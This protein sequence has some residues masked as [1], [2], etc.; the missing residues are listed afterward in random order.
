VDR[1]GAW[2]SFLLAL[3][4]AA[5]AHLSLASGTWAATIRSPTTGD[6][7]G[8]NPA[9][10]S[11][12]EAVQSANLNLPVGGCTAGDPGATDRISFSSS[13]NGS[14]ILLS[15]G[16]LSTTSDL[17]IIGNGPTQTIV[18][19][20]GTTQPFLISGGATALLQD[21]TIV[22]G[23]AINGGAVSNAGSLVLVNSSISGS[24]ATL[25]G[26]VVNAG[27]VVSV[28]N[29]T[30]S[31]NSATN[32]GAIHNIGGGTVSVS[33]STLSGNA[34]TIGGAI[35]NDAGGAVS[36]TATTLSGNAGGSSAGGIFNFSTGTVSLR[37]TL[38]DTGATGANCAGTIESFGSNLADDATCFAAAGTDQVVGNVRIGPLADNGG[39]TR[40]HALAANS[41]AIDAVQ[42]ACTSDGSDG[43]R[44]LATDQRGAMRPSLGRGN[45]PARCDVGAYELLSAG[46]LQFSERAYRVGE[47]GPDATITIVRTG[48]DAGPAGA[49]LTLTG[50]TATLSEDYSGATFS[51]L[52]ADGE[53]SKLVLVPIVDDQLG[54][55]EE[56]VT[57]RL[58]DPTDG[59]RL[60]SSATAAL[61]IVDNDPT[62]SLSV[63]D[64]TLMEGSGGTTSFVFTVTLSPPSGQQVTVMAQTGDDL[65]LAPGDYAAVGAT[66]L[67]FAPTVTSQTFTVQ[68]VGD[69]L[70]ESNETFLVTLSRPRSAEIADPQRVGTILN[71]DSLATLSID[72][73]T[74]AEGTGGVT[75][76]VFTV[77]L[78]APLPREV[79]VQAQTADGNATA[80]VDYA[81][82]P[83]TPIS[84]PPGVTSQQIAIVVSADAVPEGPEN[85]A[86]N[87]SGAVGATIAD[88]QGVGIISDD[89]TPAAPPV[90]TVAPAPVPAPGAVPASP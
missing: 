53:T 6:E 70:N 29:S 63:D 24:S 28:F 60:D 58:G 13:T 54:E 44:P 55:Q 68:V 34:A 52:F 61:T 40:T 15:A 89:D 18:D 32:G 41:P 8:S 11:L 12:R 65:A 76:L 49:T 64:V 46:E 19:G 36:L 81:G 72:D 66:M 79:T 21:L 86:V 74:Q 67:T 39:P 80:G 14:A 87:L 33:S 43:G 20:G 9:A 56:T 22:N 78:S 47:E 27:G 35:Y 57:L 23:R 84:F 62:P 2:R 7:N 50:G 31:G 85:F 38:L 42:G 88:P 75:R 1:S 83:L 17:E 73:V 77:T 10:C 82:L 37:G 45:G 30:L 3:T 90:P 4:L 71:D 51:V 5:F 48:G 26:A 59:V 69:A 25:G 16:T